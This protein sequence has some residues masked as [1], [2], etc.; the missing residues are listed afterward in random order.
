MYEKSL[1]SCLLVLKVAGNRVSVA[2]TRVMLNTLTEEGLE[3]PTSS[4]SLVYICIEEVLCKVTDATQRRVTQRNSH[5]EIGVQK[6]M[7][8]IVRIVAMVGIVVQIMPPTCLDHLYRKTNPSA[9]RGKWQHHPFTILHDLRQ[10]PKS[11]SELKNPLHSSAQKENRSPIREGL[12]SPP[13]L[14]EV[15]LLCPTHS[16]PRRTTQVRPGSTGPRSTRISP[17]PAHS[18]SFPAGPAWP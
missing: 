18:S 9:G 8:G 6:G 1:A 17:Q 3:K 7:V 15:L 4:I 13:E 16:S 11:A 10:Q 2:M 12:S 5:R 14:L